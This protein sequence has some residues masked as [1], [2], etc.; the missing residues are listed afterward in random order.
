MHRL[1]DSHRLRLVAI[2]CILTVVFAAVTTILPTD[3]LLAFDWN[4]FFKRGWNV[5]L[6]YPPWTTI[7][8]SH[9]SWPLL[10]GITLSTFS[11][12]VLQRASSFFSA[13]MA[14]CTLPLFWTIF[15]GQ[16]DGLALLGVVGLPWLVPLVLVKPQIAMFAIL[17]QRKALIVAAG[18]LALSFLIWGLW[19][20]DMLTYHTNEWETWPQDIAVGWLGIPAFVVLVWKMPKSDVDWWMLAG[21]TITPFL[22]PYN[23]LPLMPTVA[24]LPKGWATA[25]AAASWLPLASNW[26]G[27]FGWYLGWLSIAIIGFGLVVS[28][29]LGVE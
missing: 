26:I 29:R 24:R 25:A 7:L 28:E 11:V 1:K 17:S 5:P 9:L 15:L 16:L 13:M 4:H 14:F 10:I 8:V 2:W 22:I 23:L 19:P 12:A 3:G 6:F 27:P 21:T 20:L 18:F